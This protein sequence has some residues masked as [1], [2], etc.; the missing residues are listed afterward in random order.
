MPLQK[1]VKEGD[2]KSGGAGVS[3]STSDTNK[4][5]DAGKAGL[6][7]CTTTDDEPRKKMILDEYWVSESLPGLV[8]PAAFL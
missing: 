1:A 3:C 4:E 7:E 5:P 2:H 6:M 8:P